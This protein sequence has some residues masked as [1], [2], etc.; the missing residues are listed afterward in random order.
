MVKPEMQVSFD[1]MVDEFERER[2]DTYE[3]EEDGPEREVF[4]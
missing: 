1:K 2:D 4:S 3:T